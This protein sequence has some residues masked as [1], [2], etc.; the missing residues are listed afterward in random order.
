MM[1][2]IAKKNIWFSISG[3]LMLVSLTATMLWGLNL[4]IDFTGGSLLEVDFGKPVDSATIKAVMDQ[5][6]AKDSQVVSTKQNSYLIKSQTITEEQHQK[7]ISGLK[8]YEPKEQRFDSIGPSI[9]S[10]LKQKSILA[11]VAVLLAIIGYIAYAFRK[12]SYPVAS[13]KYGVAAVIALFH[14]V[15]IPVGIF[16]F[17]GHYFG[18]QVDAL[19]ITA[20]LTVLGFSVHDTIVVFDRIR[21]NLPKMQ[22]KTL[23]ELVNFSVNETM[24][25][26]INTSLTVFLV[27]LAILLFGGASIKYFV[28]TLLIGIIFGTYSS[29]FIA[30]PLLVL[31][32]KWQKR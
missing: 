20:L 8:Q 27:L 6:N 10:E 19:F 1:Q 31:F 16:A 28:L 32:Y 13:W 22:D 14:D 30:S 26:S 7:I 4:G 5:N 23:S 11:V 18:I 3:V 12:A 15:F 25:R 29:I 2:I 21:E 17:L 24:I 9:G